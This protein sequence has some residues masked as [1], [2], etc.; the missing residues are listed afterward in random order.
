MQPYPH[1]YSVEA[2]AAATGPVTL[3]SQGLPSLETAPPREFDGPGDRW[4]PETLLVG[5]VADCFTLS[6]RAIAAASK[7]EWTALRCRAEGKLDRSE[8]VARF[9]EMTLRVRLEIPPGVEVERARR[10]LEKSEKACL[11][12]NSLRLTPVLACEIETRGA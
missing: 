5:A 12:T 3:S 6:F 9:T 8:G 11:I 1:E 2:S 4:S 10:L 7:L